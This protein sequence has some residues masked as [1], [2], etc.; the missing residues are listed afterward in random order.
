MAL[1]RY[2]PERG[3]PETTTQYGFELGPEPVVVD[4]PRALAKFRGSPF[5]EVIEDADPTPPA[6]PPDPPANVGYRA[7]HNG[8]GRFIIVH[9]DKD[10]KVGAGLN[11]ADADAFNALSDDK[12]AAYVEAMPK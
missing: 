10:E 7:V 6:T 1:V 12:K 2:I 5:F 8:G 9:G 4:D 3:T 11:K